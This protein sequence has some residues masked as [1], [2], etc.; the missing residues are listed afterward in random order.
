M[1]RFER[2][3]GAGEFRRHRS[4]DFCDRGATGRYGCPPDTAWLRSVGC[5]A[6]IPALVASPVV[7]G[8]HVNFLIGARRT[9]F[10]RHAP[11]GN[12]FRTANLSIWSDR[13]RCIKSPFALVVGVNRSGP[14][15]HILLFA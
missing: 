8:R 4:R 14:N 13:S 10:V 7:Q 3:L 11:F 12:G 5:L 15:P 1:G 9:Q 2:G 6:K